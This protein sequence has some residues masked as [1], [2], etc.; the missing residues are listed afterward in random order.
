[1]KPLVMAALAAVLWWSPAQ[2]QENDAWDL[3][4]YNEPKKV[5]AVKDRDVKKAERLAKKDEDFP[6]LD[7]HEQDIVIMAIAKQLAQLRKRK[8]I[9]W[10]DSVNI[11]IKVSDTDLKALEKKYPYAFKIGRNVSVKERI[12]VTPGKTTWEPS[13]EDVTGEPVN[14]LFADNQWKVLA[15]SED[16]AALKKLVDE[17][18]A[19]MGPKDR[20]TGLHIK[21]SA[22]TL[23]CTAVEDGKPINNLRLSELRAE[24][25]KVFVL[26]YLKT[27]HGIELPEEVVTIDFAGDNKN[28]TSGPDDF[29]GTGDKG[30][31]P[32]YKDLA[33]YAQHRYVRTTLSL[34]RDHGKPVTDPG[35]QVCKARVVSMDADTESWKLRIKLPH[36]RWPRL[37]IGAFFK[38][39]FHGKKGALPCPKW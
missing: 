12:D 19:D 36:I 18:L 6:S 37:H 32:P 17:L 31:G 29:Y 9:Q 23:R 39:I 2:A 13:F 22:S 34:Y 16:A 3:E 5:E 33:E 24:A 28:G 15:D 11:D 1:M 25:A 21:S 20:V 4:K 26:D 10:V 14:N 8:G 27:K 38:K 30:N 35:T 7:K